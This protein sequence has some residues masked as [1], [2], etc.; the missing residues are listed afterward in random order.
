MRTLKNCEIDVGYLK[1]LGEWGRFTAHWNIRTNEIC[2]M[3]Y[4]YHV[5]S[6]LSFKFACR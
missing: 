6:V 1:H 5:P 3:R 2:Q 4:Y